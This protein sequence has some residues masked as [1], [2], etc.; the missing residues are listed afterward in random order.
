MI[1]NGLVVT[2]SYTLHNSRENFR[3]K[4]EKI[5]IFGS[6]VVHHSAVVRV[7]VAGICKVRPRNVVAKSL[8]NCR[9]VA[10]RVK[11]DVRLHWFGLFNTQ[12]DCVTGSRLL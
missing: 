7:Q 1:Q 2:D 6:D 5:Q 4:L 12:E 9:A 10:V 11:E 3:W 8:R